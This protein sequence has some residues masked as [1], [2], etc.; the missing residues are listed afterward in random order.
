MFIFFQKWQ[1]SEIWRGAKAWNLGQEW[2][3]K[4]KCFVL[5]Y[6]FSKELNQS[7]EGL[8]SLLLSTLRIDPFASTYVGVLR[9]V[10]GTSE[11]RKSIGV[12]S[13]LCVDLEHHGHSTDVNKYLLLLLRQ[14]GVY[15][16]VHLVFTERTLYL[17]MV[18]FKEDRNLDI[19]EN[20]IASLISN[21]FPFLI[22]V[23]PQM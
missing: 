2:G 23:I 6:I 22:S 14:N 21:Y 4:H 7:L 19:E 10:N 15:L 9:N 20:S 1:L 17:E 18:Y 8:F 5:S 12:E 11:Q 13:R 16:G 3:L